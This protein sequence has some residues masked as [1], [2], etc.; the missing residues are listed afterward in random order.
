MGS[1]TEAGW[2]VC[3][4]LRAWLLPTVCMWRNASALT[5]RPFLGRRARYAWLPT[6]TPPLPAAAFV[7][8]IPA[9]RSLPHNPAP[10]R[11]AQALCAAACFGPEDWP[12]LIVCPSTMKLVWRDA[13]LDWLPPALQPEPGN[14]VVIKDG[15]VGVWWVGWVGWGG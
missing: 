4:G 9:P 3:E 7:A 11:L 13:V 8:P 1:P 6:P 5:W 2:P 14:L 10:P 15:K 12:L